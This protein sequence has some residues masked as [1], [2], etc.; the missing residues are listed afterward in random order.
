[1]GG[2]INRLYK[3]AKH[4]N[5]DAACELLE[6][7]Y[8]DIFAYLRRLCGNRHT[9]E[10]L[11]QETFAKAW[12]SL[13]SLKHNSRFST[14]LYKIAYNSCVDWRRRNSNI[15]PCKSDAWWDECVDESP[16]P[17]ANVAQRQ[18]A[19]RLHKAVQQLDNKKKDVVHLHYYQGLS[20][21]ETAR[22]LNIA[23]ST[24]KYRLRE[25]L[26]ILKNQLATEQKV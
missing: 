13:G 21:R 11:T 9:A 2:R 1:M 6:T 3:Q 15:A 26:R 10:D 5:K 12:S 19:I 24:V 20:L 18:M 22:A 25:V 23:T 8:A 16:G 17:F 14:W 7:Y 4:G